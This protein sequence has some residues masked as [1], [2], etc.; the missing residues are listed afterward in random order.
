M[1][2]HILALA[3]LSS[4]GIA[5]LACGTSSS[6]PSGTSNNGGAA[7]TREAARAPA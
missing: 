1:R 5:A 3:G 6:S 7:A 4:L 2:S